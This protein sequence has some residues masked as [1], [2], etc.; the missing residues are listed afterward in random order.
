MFVREETAFFANDWLNCY[1]FKMK[2]GF[3]MKI[4]FLFRGIYNKSGDL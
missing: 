2:I 3:K 4:Y 1:C